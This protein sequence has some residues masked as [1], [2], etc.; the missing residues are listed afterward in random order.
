MFK[1]GLGL[2]CCSFLGIHPLFNLFRYLFVVRPL[3]DKLNRSAIGGVG[4]QVR[5]TQVYIQIPLLSTNPGSRSEWFFCDNP[6][7]PLP[8]FRGVIAPQLPKWNSSDVVKEL[9]NDPQVKFLLGAVNELKK[10]GATGETIV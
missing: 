1:R 5:S 2:P 6:P 7:P 3:P 9:A 10:A 4:L 8:D